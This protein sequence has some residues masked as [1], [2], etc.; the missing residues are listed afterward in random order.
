VTMRFGRAVFMAA[1]TVVLTV[2][3]FDCGGMTTPEQA[4]RC[5]DRMPCSSQGHHGQDCC[6]TMPAMHAPFVQPPSV[7]RTGFSLNAL[8]VLPALSE[9]FGSASSACN[10]ST[11]CHAPPLF[12]S[13][14][15]LPLRI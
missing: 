2:Y 7:H 15:P 3:A 14:P 6:K 4:M 8:A 12:H 13:P 9:S 1:L 10:L 5:C 11:N